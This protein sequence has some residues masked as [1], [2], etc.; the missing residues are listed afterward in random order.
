MK[1]EAIDNNFGGNDVSRI[2][3]A[4]VNSHFNIQSKRFLICVATLYFPNAIW[5][6]LKFLFLF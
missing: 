5:I 3:Y 1:K 4:S 2:I 6:F